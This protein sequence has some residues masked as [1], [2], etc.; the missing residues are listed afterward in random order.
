M[1]YKNPPIDFDLF[2]QEY[3]IPSAPA[4]GIIKDV[5]LSIVRDGAKQY[6]I[7]DSELHNNNEY[8]LKHAVLEWRATTDLKNTLSKN[9]MEFAVVGDEIK[10]LVGISTITE[11]L[12]K[13]K[14][15]SQKRTP[16]K[17][18]GNILIKAGDLVKVENEMKDAESELS[19]QQA[20]ALGALVSALRTLPQT[21]QPQDILKPQKALL[22]ASEAGFRLTTEQLSELLGLSRQTIASKKSGFIKLGFSYEKIKEGSSTLWKVSQVS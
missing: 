5:G 2:R 16:N 15:P 19:A 20:S 18:S 13:P 8:L 10:G 21:N 11:E 1:D 12:V 17:P 9:F 6:I 22:E 3:S 14:T 4:R 7:G